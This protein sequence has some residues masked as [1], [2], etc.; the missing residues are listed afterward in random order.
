[1]AS[2]L[3]VYGSLRKA[4]GHPMHALLARHC[5]FHAK[6]HMQ[7]RLFEVDGYPAAITSRH[8][9]DRVHGEVYRIIDEQV[10]AA[11]DDYEECTERF[12]E[13]H[14]YVRQPVTA[15]LQ[16]GTSITAWVYLYNRNASSLER[17]TSG[18]YVSYLRSK[19]DS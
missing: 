11:L 14:E 15:I 17:I 9:G 6:G 12:P 1:M 16:D 19:Q 8:R 18:D 2:F 10:L 13:P 3:F 7:G 5:A 4:A